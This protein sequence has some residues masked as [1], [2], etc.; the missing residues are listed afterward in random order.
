VFLPVIAFVQ[1]DIE[2]KSNSTLKD[3][4]KVQIKGNAAT[5]THKKIKKYISVAVKFLL[6]FVLLLELKII[7]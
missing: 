5:K 1:L 6:L 7:F 3:P 4:Q 2:K